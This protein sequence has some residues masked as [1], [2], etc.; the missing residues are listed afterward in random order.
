MKGKETKPQ[1]GRHSTQE[2]KRENR[3]KVEG[4]VTERDKKR[5]SSE[6]GR[7]GKRVQKYKK[8]AREREN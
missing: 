5:H 8:A 4:R 7:R 3:I 1:K 2:R 6:R